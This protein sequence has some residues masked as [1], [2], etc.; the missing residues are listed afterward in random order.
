MKEIDLPVTTTFSMTFDMEGLKEIPVQMIDGLKVIPLGTMNF[1]TSGNDIEIARSNGGKVL[2]STTT[3][4]EKKLESIISS[5][6][7]SLFLEPNS[8]RS[9]FEHELLGSSSMTLEFKRT[10]VNKIIDQENYQTG[11]E[12]DDLIKKLADIIKWRNAFAHGDIRL[13]NVQGVFLKYYSGGNK[14]LDLNDEFW[15]KVVE[16]YSSCVKY[17]DGILGKI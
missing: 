8:Q 1:G 15:D 14:Q 9:F 11:K 2:Y 5:Y 13:D 16:T 17:L 4:I 7:F 3:T 12:K 6:L 10:L